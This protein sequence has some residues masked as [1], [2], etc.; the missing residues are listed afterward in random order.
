MFAYC[1]IGGTNRTRRASQLAQPQI[2]FAQGA[3]HIQKVAGA[4][5]GTQQRMSGRDLRNN[6][7][8]DEHLILAGG[9]SS[10][11]FTAKISR[12]AFQAAQKLAEPVAGQFC[13]ESKTQKEAA[14]NA[15][16]GGDV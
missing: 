9:V 11:R 14:W 16:H 13:W 10:R 5:T 6:G 3:T 8:A 2:R 4:C 12:S 15:T 1:G 7:E